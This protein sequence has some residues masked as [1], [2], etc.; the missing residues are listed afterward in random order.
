MKNVGKKEDKIK[1]LKN[2]AKLNLNVRTWWRD[3]DGIDHHM[4]EILLL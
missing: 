2:K 1:Y 4:S 3:F